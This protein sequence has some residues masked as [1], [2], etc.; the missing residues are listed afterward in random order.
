MNGGVDMGAKWYD[1]CLP[2]DKERTG[3]EPRRGLLRWVVWFWENWP[4]PRRAGEGVNAPGRHE[5]HDHGAGDAV[6]AVP[7]RR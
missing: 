7:W 3:N 2:S 1:D 5:E 6:C 4:S